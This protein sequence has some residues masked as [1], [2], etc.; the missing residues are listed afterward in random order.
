[1]IGALWSLLLGGSQALAGYNPG[2]VYLASSS[3][4]FDIYDVS[5]GGDVSKSV[6]AQSGSYSAGQLAWSIDLSVMYLGMYSTNEVIQIDSSGTVS[7][8]AIGLS[9]PTGLIMLSDGT[10][11][12]AEYNSGEITDITAGGNFVLVTAMT[13]G[14]NGPRSFAELHD[15]TVLIGTQEDGKVWE[16]D[17]STHATSSFATGLGSVRTIVQDPGTWDRAIASKMLWSS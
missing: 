10:L 7:T 5:A 1:M 14:F 17:P 11:L 2:D 13:S 16:F 12:V 3:G 15:G 8:F 4:D 9:G 6:I